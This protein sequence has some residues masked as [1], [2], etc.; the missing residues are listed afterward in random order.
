MKKVD[1][2]SVSCQTE[3]DEEILEEEVARISVACQTSL[4][5][6][7]PEDSGAIWVVTRLKALLEEEMAAHNDSSGYESNL[8]SLE[9]EENNDDISSKSD[10]MSLT[11]GSCEDLVP[12]C[13]S[14]Q[15][16]PGL[17]NEEQ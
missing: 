12:I 4:K 6:E 17:Y 8:S 9:D 15:L 11:T 3:V 1:R 16:V 7:E 13:E 14:T 2:V 10:V 5:P